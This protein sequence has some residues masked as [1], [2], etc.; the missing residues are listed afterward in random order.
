MMR[1]HHHP[2]RHNKVLQT[3]LPPETWGAPMSKSTHRHSPPADACLKILFGKKID[4]NSADF[5]DDP[6]MVRI[7]LSTT[8]VRRGHG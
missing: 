7:Q 6:K 5:F 4:P 8:E 2:N 1:A 3:A